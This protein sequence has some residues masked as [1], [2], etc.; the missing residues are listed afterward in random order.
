[1]H[2]TLAQIGQFDQNLS[3][4][5]PLWPKS[6]FR[7]SHLGQLQFDLSHLGP[8][9]FGLTNLGPNLTLNHGL[10]GPRNF[11]PRTI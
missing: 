8:G 11:A 10:F 4:A 2:H 3:F 5:H 9:H 7:Q 6:Q 1:M